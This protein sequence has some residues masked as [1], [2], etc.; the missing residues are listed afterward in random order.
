VCKVF[1]T[2]TL[3]SYSLFEYNG[4]LGKLLG[5]TTDW[6]WGGGGALVVEG[7]EAGEDLLGGEGVG[8]G[9]GGEDGLVEGAVGVVEPG[10]ALVVEVGEGAL[11]EVFFWR[12]GRVEPSVAETDEGAGGFGDG[13][14]AGVLFFGGFGA[15]DAE[16]PKP[17]LLSRRGMAEAVLATF[18]HRFCV[19]LGIR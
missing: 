4:N 2:E 9:V 14:D 5:G 16:G 7:Q 8:P 17:F 13:V 6:G 12:V 1:K 11:F 15:G 3:A 10:G 19:G 18:K